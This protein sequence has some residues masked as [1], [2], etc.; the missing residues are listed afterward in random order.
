MASL[1]G[2]AAADGNDAAPIADGCCDEAGGTDGGAGS[3]VC[4]V[5]DSASWTHKHQYSK[6]PS[7]FG[8]ALC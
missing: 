5:C 8:V 3:H 4:V 6:Q 2:V 1:V 7:L